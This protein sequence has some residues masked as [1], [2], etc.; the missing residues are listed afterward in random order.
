MAGHS[1]M[2]TCKK[3]A[4]SKSLLPINGSTKQ[5]YPSLRVFEIHQLKFAISSEN[6]CY[7][8]SDVCCVNKLALKNIATGNPYLKIFQR[9]K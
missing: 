8:L 2:S 4:I 1:Q 9:G 6:I 7:T 5:L 3:M